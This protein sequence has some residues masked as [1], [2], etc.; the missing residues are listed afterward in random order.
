MMPIYPATA[1][2]A[3]LVVVALE[4]AVWRTGLFRARSYWTS[5]LIV[6]GFMI[7]V[8]G[9]LTKLSAPIVIYNPPDVSGWRPVWDIL[10]EEYCYAFA[11]ITLVLL[12]WVRAGDEEPDDETA[13]ETAVRTAT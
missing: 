7:V 13:D 10:A 9:W 1:I 5:L 11:L 12:C 2:A 4:L 3:C 6:F 8:D